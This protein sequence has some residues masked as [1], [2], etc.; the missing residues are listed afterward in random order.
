VFDRRDVGG[1]L[2]ILGNPGAGKTTT[3]LDLAAVLIQRAN[4]QPDEPIPVMFNLSSWQNEKQSITDW[5]LSELK[6]KYG[7]SPKLGKTWLSEK[8]SA[9]PAGWLG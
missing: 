8:S 4:D 2:L 3:M 5:L 7:V 9:A 6:L 1:K